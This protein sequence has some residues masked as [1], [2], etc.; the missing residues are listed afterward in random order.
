MGT[1]LQLAKVNTFR[2]WV[3]NSVN[4]ERACGP[5][6]QFPLMVPSCRGWDGWLASLT[7]WTRIWANQEIV[8]DWEVGRA[9]VHGVERVTH[10][11]ATEQQP[12]SCKVTVQYWNQSTDS[13]I[14]WGL[15]Y[16]PHFY[17]WLNWGLEKHTGFSGSLTWLVWSWGGTGIQISR[18]WYDDALWTGQHSSACL[19]IH[20]TNIY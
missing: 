4:V 8:K 14:R 19:T 15:S 1:E 16:Y 12:P 17:S 5:F 10:D 18:Q 7:Q 9:A 3:H 2:R 13:L 20:L 11:L 6:A